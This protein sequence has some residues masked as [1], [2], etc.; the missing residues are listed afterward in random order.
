MLTIFAI[1]K[2]F[3]GHTKKIQSNAIHSWSNLEP[4]CEII[5]FGNEQ[6]TKEFSHNFGIH[7]ISDVKKN[8][9]GTPLL[10]DIF[11]KAQEQAR[12]DLMVFINADIILMNDFMNALKIVKK[13]SNR[14]LMVGRRLDLD[15]DFELNFDDPKWQNKLRLLSQSG[16]LHS[17]TGI[18]YFVFKRGQWSTIPPFAIGRTIYDHWLIYQIRALGIP[19]IDATQMVMA[20]HQN[21]SYSK[22]SS[23]ASINRKIASKYPFSYLFSI[24]D[25]THL[26]QQDKI[27]SA[28]DLRHLYRRMLTY[29]LI[30][31]NS[32]LFI[33]LSRFL[34]WSALKLGKK[35]SAIERSVRNK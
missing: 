17:H 3:V 27:V 5:L 34:L 33:S 10:N 15:L 29:P 24:K 19:V 35:D 2:P 14:F 28:S 30:N 20:I 21:H 13:W 4:P 31:M 12:Y 32:D 26:L 9:Y 7:N 22:I 23:E 25:A 16:R 8:E 11:Q 6:G 18:D 1:P